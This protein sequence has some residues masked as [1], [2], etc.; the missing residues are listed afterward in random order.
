LKLF[1]NIICDLSSEKHT[2]SSI[3]SCF[4]NM[5]IQSWQLKQIIFKTPKI[6]VPFF[7]F[8]GPL[9]NSINFHK[10]SGIDSFSYFT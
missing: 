10:D 3:F 4:E 2:P 5:G 6:I 7:Y 9:A 1:K 8:V